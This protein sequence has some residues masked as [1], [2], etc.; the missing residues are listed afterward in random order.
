MTRTARLIVGAVV[1]LASRDLAGAQTLSLEAAQAEARAHAPDPATLRARIT[2]AEAI[3]AQSGR[4]FRDNPVVSSSFSSGAVVGFEDEHAWAVGISQLFDLSGSRRPRVASAS[5]DLARARFQEQDGLRAL[6]ER[7]AVAVAELAYQQRIVARDQRL[8]AL[9]QLAADGAHRQLEVGQ[10]TQLDT[11]ASDLDLAGAR[12]TVEQARGDLDRSRV[13]LGRLLGRDT[14]A[15]F[16]V[17][18]PSERF[19]EV[20]AT[21][22]A[23]IVERDPRVQ[24]AAAE[25]DAARFEQRMF[26]RLAKPMPTFGIEF[27]SQRRD[28]PAGSFSG[29]PFAGSLTAV[30]PDR[31][32][33]MNIS[34]PL[35]VFDK[36]QESRARSTGRILTAEAELRVVRADVRSELEISWLALQ[37]ATRAAQAVSGTRELVDR[38]AGFLDQA[39]RAGALDAVAR[40]I[41]LRRLEEAGR[42]VDAA[43][44]DYRA[45]R[46]AWR[47]RLVP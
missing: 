22:L 5:A 6:D 35:P 13:Q 21:D 8:L 33:G 28:I 32:L 31:E 37:S 23:A 14:S 11:D 10:G 17:D 46:A 20:T 36:Q 16:A 24:A 38:D 43:I 19:D 29:A 42:Q 30:W 3:A 7:V 4:R 41:S 1:F 15:E 25:L 18:D 2:E 34:V 12:I 26:E 27:G 44:R 39:V 9:Y 40:S 45:A 47:R